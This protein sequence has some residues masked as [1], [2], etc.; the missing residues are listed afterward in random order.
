MEESKYTTFAYRYLGTLALR[1]SDY[2]EDVGKNLKKAD[3]NLTLPKYLSLALLS[4]LIVF[5]CLFVSL[6]IVIGVV[7]LDGLIGI[8]TG[9]ISSF[10]ISILGGVATFFV[11][12]IYPSI[13]IDSRRVSINHALPFATIYLSTLA[14][15]GTPPA[16]MFGLLKDFDE[17]GEIATESRKIARDVNS[18]GAD[19]ESALSRAADR[20]PSDKF[21][22]L[23]WGMNNIISTGGDLRKFLQEKSD[24]F[25]RDYRRSL[26]D[27]TD[28]L[29]LLVEIY[30]TVVIV[31]SIFM[32]IISTI[33]SAMGTAGMPIIVGLQLATVFILLPIASFALILLISSM[34]PLRS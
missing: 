5:A 28:T 12:Y 33:M 34:S 25:M 31:G 11:Y 30:I 8:V 9:V 6:V 26:D 14:G 29:S 15:T 2:F 21:R 16:S 10:F 17:Y 32:I 22:S 13:K 1:L 24:S 18:F 23:L 20:T 19:I 3:I 27:F 4:S 7:I